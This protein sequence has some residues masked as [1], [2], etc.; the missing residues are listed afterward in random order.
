MSVTLGMT[1]SQTCART[2]TL[3]DG[4]IVEDLRR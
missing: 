3:R 4:R 2:I 1:A